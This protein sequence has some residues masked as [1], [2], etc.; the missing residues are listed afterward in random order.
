MAEQPDN[1]FDIIDSLPERP[2]EGSNTSHP[3]GAT[4]DS[5]L[6]QSLYEGPRKCSC[7]I[8]WVDYLPANADSDGDDDEDLPLVVRHSV[9]RG[10]DASR[11]SIHSI[12]VRDS[13]TRDALFPVFEGFDRVHPGINYLVF[14]APFKPFFYR[15][16]QFEQAIDSCT[17]PRTKA[18][19]EH[20][21]TTVKAELAEAFAIWDE[22][23]ENG[24]I[25]YP[26][27]WTIFQPGEVLCEDVLG[28]GTPRFYYLEEL[29]DPDLHDSHLDRRLLVQYVDLDDK[30]GLIGTDFR[31]W[32]FQG[33]R[34]I[35]DLPVYP[36]RFLP[37]YSSVKQAVISRGQKFAA[38]AGVHYKE[39]ASRGSGPS[40]RIVIDSQGD[41]GYK[42]VLSSLKPREEMNCNTGG[43]TQVPPDAPPVGGHTSLRSRRGDD[44]SPEPE[45]RRDRGDR[46]D[47]R[48]NRRLPRPRAAS[49]DYLARGYS[50]ESQELDE[51]HLQICNDTVGGF[52]L[53]KRAWGEVSGL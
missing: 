47:R 20:L 48:R 29:E 3:P 36:A 31:I 38:L 10:E 1:S 5:P 19:L 43:I 15:W 53:Q 24:V 11:V 45:Y 12:E 7:C 8:N 6:V 35:T 49:P 16:S 52:C 33:T 23:V 39:Y 18:I 40:R 14:H 34:R 2:S 44:G 28:G 42:P 37:D 9:F 25:S 21:Y 51:I 46:G 41:N 27:L 26:Y 22:L 50:E 13:A 30:F 4:G 17:A 32:S